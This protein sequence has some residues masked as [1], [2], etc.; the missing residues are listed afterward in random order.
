MDLLKAYKEKEKK[1]GQEAGSIIRILVEL[2]KEGNL[3]E[4]ALDDYML[5]HL[6]AWKPELLPTKPGCYEDHKQKYKEAV[7]KARQRGKEIPSKK[8]FFCDICTHYLNTYF[9]TLQK[10]YTKMEDLEKLKNRLLKRNPADPAIGKITTILL[11]H[12]YA[13]SE[14][15]KRLRVGKKKL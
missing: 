10:N 14:E 3:T 5:E 13:D 1:I 2:L 11:E 7:D 12:R 8:L 6:E 4:E 9:D 15:Y